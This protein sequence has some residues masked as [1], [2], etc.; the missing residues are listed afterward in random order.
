MDFAPSE[1]GVRD[2]GRQLTRGQFLCMEILRDV[3]LQGGETRRHKNGELQKAEK[4]DSKRGPV[5]SASCK[6]N[7]FGKC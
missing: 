5:L 7:S 4:M 6:E 3:I 1:C 2:R